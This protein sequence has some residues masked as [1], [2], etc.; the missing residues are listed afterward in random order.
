MLRA[1]RPG[2]VHGYAAVTLDSQEGF[3]ATLDWHFLLDGFC[4]RHFL[5]DSQ[6]RNS[7]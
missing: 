4:N 7:R 3:L 1:A 5:C 6:F 2:G